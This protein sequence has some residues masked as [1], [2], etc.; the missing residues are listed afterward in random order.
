MIY[1]SGKEVLA[2]IKRIMDIEGISM[3]E[4]AFRLNK[5]QQALSRIFKTANPRFSTLVDMC[6][7]LN[8]KIDISFYNKSDTD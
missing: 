1:Y 8:I 7:A 3:K 6:N 2:E 4:L 5:S